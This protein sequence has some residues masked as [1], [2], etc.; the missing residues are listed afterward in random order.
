MDRYVPKYQKAWY[1]SLFWYFMLFWLITLQYTIH[2]QSEGLRKIWAFIW[3]Q[4][5]YHAA[6]T[7]TVILQNM[8]FFMSAHRHPEIPCNLGMAA[9]YQLGIC[10]WIYSIMHFHIGSKSWWVR[11]GQKS[12]YLPLMSLSQNRNEWHF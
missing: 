8:V 2:S 7:H 4:S 12:D 1:T 10:N 6:W 9:A 3:Y 5:H 11:F